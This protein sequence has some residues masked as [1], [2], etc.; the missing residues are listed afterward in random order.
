[1][2]CLISLKPELIDRLFKFCYQQVKRSLETNSHTLLLN[3]L[4]QLPSKYFFFN[5]LAVYSIVVF[6]SVLLNCS[7]ILTPLLSIAY[8]NVIKHKNCA[9]MIG[10]ICVHLP[11]NPALMI[12]QSGA[13]KGNL[14]KGDFC[15]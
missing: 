7:P 15:F 4:N 13:K 10:S 12:I 3:Y 6:I 1:M 14:K 11:V 8:E 5:A 2:Y 9:Y